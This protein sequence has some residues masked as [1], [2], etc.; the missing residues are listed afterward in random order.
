ML[1]K[2]AQDDTEAMFDL[3]LFAEDPPADP[4]AG[5]PPADPPASN[6]PPPSDPPEDPP[7]DPPKKDDPAKGDDPPTDTLGDWKPILPEGVELDQKVYDAVF[8]KFKEMGISAKQAD[9]LTEMYN[10]LTKDLGTRILGDINNQCQTGYD[11]AIN[12]IKADPVLGKDFEAKT[13]QINAML[14]KYG[15]ENAPA[16]FQEAL[17]AI[18]GFRGD[19]GEAVKS[20]FSTMQKIAGDWADPTTVMGSKAGNGPKTLGEVLYGKQK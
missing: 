17:T 6:D 14:T 9:G 8:P 15:G 11:A 4:P 7:A 1:K 16:M 10:E 20:L 19:G 13:G 2:L 12:E 3:Q 18:A 5:D